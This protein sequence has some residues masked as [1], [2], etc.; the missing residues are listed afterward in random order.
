MI[1][2]LMNELIKQISWRRVCGEDLIVKILT[3]PQWIG[4]FKTVRIEMDFG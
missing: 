4:D 2:V 1:G 3:R